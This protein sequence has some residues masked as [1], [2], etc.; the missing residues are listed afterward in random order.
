MKHILIVL[1]NNRVNEKIRC[2]IP[3]LS[4]YYKL[5]LYNIGEMSKE[6]KW[7]GDVDPRIKFR[8]DTYKYFEEVIEGEGFDFHGDR[9]HNIDL[10]HGYDGIIYD[11]N[12][13]NQLEDV[14]SSDNEL[15]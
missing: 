4:K 8:E 1:T 10:K 13:L 7:Y 12:R 3:E 2:I 14:S 15:H 9:I 11:D 5:S 6:T